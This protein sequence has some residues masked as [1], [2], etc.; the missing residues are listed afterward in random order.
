VHLEEYG[1]VYP[2]LPKSVGVIVVPVLLLTNY[3][4]R[5]NEANCCLY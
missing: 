2:L 1:A 3:V 5:Q 4:K